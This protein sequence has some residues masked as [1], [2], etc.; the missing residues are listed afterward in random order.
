MTK[1]KQSLRTP[2]SRMV[3]QL[4]THKARSYLVE[5]K[6]VK[7]LQKELCGRL[8][9]DPLLAQSVAHIAVEEGVV[10]LTRWRVSRVGTMVFVPEKPVIA[11]SARRKGPARSE[12]V[13]QE[14]GEVSAHQLSDDP[15]SS[16]DSKFSVEEGRLSGEVSLFD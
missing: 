2:T 8:G 4:E 11:T 15:V 12:K 10:R 1:E 6:D 3:F 16:L 5:V 13:P 14:E 7:E 9:I